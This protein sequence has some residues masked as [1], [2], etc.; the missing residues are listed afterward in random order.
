MQLTILP[1]SQ[2]DL[3]QFEYYPEW[4]Q[5]SADNYFEFSKDYIDWNQNQ[6]NIYGKTFDLPRQEAIFGDKPYTYSYSKGRVVLTAQ[7]W[8]TMLLALRNKI[9]GFTGCKFPLVIGN[10]YLDGSQHI[11]WHDDGRP[12]LGANP[13]IASVSLGASRVF[14]IRK[15]PKGEIV[16]IKLNHGDLLVMPPGF[17]EQ[18]LHRIQKTSMG[19][20][21]RINWTFRPWHQ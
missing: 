17:Q 5:D 21:L 10:R 16:S 18:Y 15:K 6:F 8:P 12:E 4:L 14:Q 7:P 9:Q 3:V 19:A 1:E 20:D 13:A 2:S 11:G